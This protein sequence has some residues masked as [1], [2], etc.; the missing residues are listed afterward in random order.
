M[1]THDLPYPP[2]FQIDY[3]TDHHEERRRRALTSLALGDVLSEIDDLIAQEPDPSKHPCAA[4]AAWLLE[5]QLTP[6]DGGQLFDGWKALCLAAI[7]RL[8]AQ[9][10]QGED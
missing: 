7:D 2:D 9:R 4:L 8:V 10:L 1:S 6:L 3:H 5:R